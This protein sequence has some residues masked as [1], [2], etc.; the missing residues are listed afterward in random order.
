MPPIR[1]C[2]GSLSD[3]AK[4]S[5]LRKTEIRKRAARQ[6]AGELMS[7]IASGSLDPYDGYRS[8]YMLWC[9]NNA[10]VPELR[11]MFRL[12]GIE[13][14]GV[15]SVTDEFRAKIRSLASEISVEFS[16]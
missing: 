16:K 5:P 2:R 3:V 8:L 9:G 4:M 11:K 10:A 14:D 7:A 6:R 13:P 12:K 15:L 1:I